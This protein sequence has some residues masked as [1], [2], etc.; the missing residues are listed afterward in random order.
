MISE[1]LFCFCLLNTSSAEKI[2]VSYNY[3]LWTK[4]DRWIRESKL[5]ETQLV[6]FCYCQ[7]S[8][9]G[10]QSVKHTTLQPSLI[11]SLGSKISAPTQSRRCHVLFM[12]TGSSSDSADMVELHP[13]VQLHNLYAAAYPLAGESHSWLGGTSCL[14]GPWLVPLRL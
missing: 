10:H 12:V 1:H 8:I 3:N 5:G 2:Q 13:I 4:N 9:Q 7:E 14:Y 6:A 11:G